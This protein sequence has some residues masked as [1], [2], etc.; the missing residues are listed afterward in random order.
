M[1]S[2]VEGD[3]ETMQVNCCADDGKHIYLPNGVFV[4]FEK[5][6]VYTYVIQETDEVWQDE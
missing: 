5:Q 4:C 6:D 3:V 2:T 1:G